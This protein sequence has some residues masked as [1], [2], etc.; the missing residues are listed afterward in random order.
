[1]FGRYFEAWDSQERRRMR[2][3]ERV[4]TFSQF[5]LFQPNLDFFTEN[6][7]TASDA[8][9]IIQHFV[10]GPVAGPTKS[11][12]RVSLNDIVLTATTSST[13]D[14]FR[15]SVVKA[16]FTNGEQSWFDYGV[17]REFVDIVVFNGV[18]SVKLAR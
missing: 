11:Y 4:P 8:H 2:R 16:F 15:R 14:N 7:F 3:G 17:A 18:S 5:Q 13:G 9:S 10:G 1:V 6:S 12:R